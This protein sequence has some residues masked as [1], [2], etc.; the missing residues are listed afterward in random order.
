M[1]PQMAKHRFVVFESFVTYLALDVASRT[2]VAVDIYIGFSF[3]GFS[4]SRHTSMITTSSSSRLRPSSMI[5]QIFITG[6]ATIYKLVAGTP[7]HKVR[8]LEVHKNTS[9]LTDG[10]PQRVG[11]SNLPA[12]GAN[13]LQDHQRT[14]PATPT[15]VWQK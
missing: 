13:G 2:T 12:G 10:K 14:E 11:T 5:S 15:H 9:D 4:S 7:R 8:I 3:A 1:A 6:A